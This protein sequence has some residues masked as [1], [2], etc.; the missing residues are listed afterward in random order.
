M[1]VSYKT[2]ISWLHSL[3][4]F[5]FIILLRDIKNDLLMAEMQ[6]ISTA[7]PYIE[8][9]LVSVLCYFIAKSFFY[10]YFNIIITG[11]LPKASKAQAKVPTVLQWPLRTY[12]ALQFH[13]DSTSVTAKTT[14]FYLQ[15]LRLWGWYLL[16]VDPGH[17]VP[18]CLRV[19][20]SVTSAVTYPES[21]AHNA[22]SYFLTHPF[23]MARAVQVLFPAIP[24]YHI[25]YAIN[26][27]WS[28]ALG[29]VE[30]EVPSS[31]AAM[32]VIDAKVAIPVHAQT[33]FVWLFVE[34]TFL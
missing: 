2:A 1:S 23:N 26:R 28:W 24:I 6:I 34:K 3:N 30:S 19:S 15:N 21:H 22:F 29:S 9:F 16:H 7:W 20:R 33:S 18:A 13:R 4:S 12:F 11:I 27:L 31:A 14:D 17:W 5:P 10:G 32:A 25:D 8:I